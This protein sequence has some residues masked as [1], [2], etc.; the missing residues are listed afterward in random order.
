MCTCLIVPHTFLLGGIDGKTTKKLSGK[1]SNF[2]LPGGDDKN[3][4]KIFV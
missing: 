2:P 1:M 3:L 4:V